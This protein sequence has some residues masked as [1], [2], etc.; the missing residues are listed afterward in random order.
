[1]VEP[2]AWYKWSLGSDDEM[3]EMEE[4][5]DGSSIGFTLSFSAFAALVGVSLF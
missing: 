4:M 1:M 5:E 3:E 2:E